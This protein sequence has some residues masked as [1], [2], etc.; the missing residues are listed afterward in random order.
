MLSALTPPA[1]QEPTPTHNGLGET[2][3]SEGIR[4]T[5]RNHLLVHLHT[6]YT[7]QHTHT[8]TQTE[9]NRVCQSLQEGIWAGVDW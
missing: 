1:V 5:R 3:H 9:N 6:P 4:Q 7:I 8:Y 2:K